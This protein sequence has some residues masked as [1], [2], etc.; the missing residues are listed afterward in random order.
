M[1]RRRLKRQACDR[2][3]W[4]R[5]GHAAF[6][7]GLCL[8]LDPQ[9]LQLETNVE[10]RVGLYLELQLNLHRSYPLSLRGRVVWVHRS[11]SAFR[12]GLRLQSE[13]GEVRSLIHWHS[14]WAMRAG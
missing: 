4:F 14:R 11:G 1:E 10:V 9:G 7:P 2:P 3:I 6:H 12:V 5:H 8:D 13:V